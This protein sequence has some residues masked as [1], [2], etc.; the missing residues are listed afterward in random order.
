MTRATTTTS[1]SLT[2]ATR[3]WPK[4]SGSGDCLRGRP[5]RTH[6]SQGSSGAGHGATAC[7]GPRVA[8]PARSTVRSVGVALFLDLGCLAAQP[9][10]V[11]ELGPADVAAAVDLDL[12]DD[13]AV[14]REGRSTPTP[15]LTLRTVKASRTPSPGPGSRHPANTWIRDRLPSTTLTCTLTVS[16]GR[17]A[18]MSLR[19]YAWSSS[20]MSLLMCLFLV[21]ATGH[22]VGVQRE[23]PRAEMIPL[24]QECPGAGNSDQSATSDPSQ[25]NLLAGRRVVAPAVL[26]GVAE[27]GA[28]PVDGQ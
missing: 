4:V 2:K 27:L 3:C 1:S 6:A 7:R 26:R 28:R 25:R 5:F 21:S 15:K 19:S 17:K 23:S 11:V 12:V 13:R 14:H 10:Q 9:A 22:H 24:W 16:P 18:G 8:Q 20:V